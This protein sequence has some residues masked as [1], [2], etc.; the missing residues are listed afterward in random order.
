MFESK[1]FFGLS[2]IFIAY[3]YSKYTGNIGKE[4]TD[5]D[6]REEA[7]FESWKTISL[8]RQSFSKIIVG[9]VGYRMRAVVYT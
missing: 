2:A 6:E 7:V 4:E 1:V 9:Y 5:E 8:P 3:L